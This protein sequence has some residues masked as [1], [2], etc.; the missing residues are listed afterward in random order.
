MSSRPPREPPGVK[1]VFSRRAGS[2]PI[3]WTSG[4]SQS[5]VALDVLKEKKAALGW[6]NAAG[7]YYELSFDELG[8]LASLA[9]I[10][11]Q[12]GESQST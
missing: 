7:S 11:R 6:S 2:K 9:A 3:A 4:S 12:A 10:N 5:A 8:D 1:A